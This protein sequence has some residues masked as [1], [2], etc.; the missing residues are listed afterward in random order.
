MSLTFN[1]LFSL[2]CQA[3]RGFTLPAAHFLAD[4]LSLAL[5]RVHWKCPGKGILKNFGF[6]KKHFPKLTLGLEP[7]GCWDGL[8]VS[9]ASAWGLVRAHGGEKE[10]SKSPWSPAPSLLTIW[11]KVPNTWISFCV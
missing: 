3:G 2:S 10:E 9:M 4:K 8:S 6:F 1:I 5:V 7:A 11:P